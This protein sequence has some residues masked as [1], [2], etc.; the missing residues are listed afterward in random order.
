MYYIVWDFGYGWA[1]DPADGLMGGR[2][3]GKADTL[4]E[5]AQI[6]ADYL[7]VCRREHGA[8]ELLVYQIID[9]DCVPTDV[10]AAMSRELVAA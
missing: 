4:E 2:N 8:G 7:P 1:P 3:I 9:G 5:A 6:V 10:Y